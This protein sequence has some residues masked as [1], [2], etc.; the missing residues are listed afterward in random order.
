MSRIDALLTKLCPDGVEFRTLKEIFVTKNG[1]TPSTT[2]K[3]YWT[4][5][6]VPWFRMEDIRE[7]GRILGDSIQKITKEAV[8]GGRYFPA[9]SII[10]ATSATI[11]EHA[12]ITVPHLSNQRFTSLALKSEFASRIDMKFAFYYCFLLDDWCRK[13][14]TTSSFAS[15][16]MS[17]FKEFRFPIPPLEIQQ[18]I[19]AILDRFTKLEAEL[20]ARRRQYQHYRDT[21]LSFAERNDSQASKQQ[22]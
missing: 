15:V 20:E 21:L 3:D 11:G 1:Y 5:G 22:G 13:N 2:N 10:I 16:D 9:N 6:T 8:K 18:E 4:D 17:G 14:T 7:N 12:L 19:V